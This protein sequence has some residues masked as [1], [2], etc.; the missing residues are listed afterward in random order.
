MKKKST[1]QNSIKLLPVRPLQ[2]LPENNQPWVKKEIKR[3]YKES[4]AEIL[5]QNLESVE[6][7]KGVK[8]Q[9]IEKK[10]RLEEEKRRKAK[11]R[12]LR[13]LEEETNRK[14][15]IE[16]RIAELEGKESQLIEDLQGT[17]EMEVNAM[18]DLKKVLNGEMTD[19]LDKTLNVPKYNLNKSVEKEILDKQGSREAVEEEVEEEREEERE[20]ED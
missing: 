16:S 14:N 19:S 12:I 2:R 11:E 10:Q 18:E 6:V 17:N 7:I 9:G 3:Q 1:F 13:Q 15:E 4:K 20:E 5:K 8:Q